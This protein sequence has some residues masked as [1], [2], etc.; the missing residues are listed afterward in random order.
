MYSISALGDM[1]ADEKRMD[2]YAATLQRAVTAD[3]AV[4]DIG[5]GTGIFALL[6]CQFG[7]RHVYAV[8]PD[9]AI[10]VARRIAHDNGYADQIT[11]IQDFSTRIS[12]PEP[13][14]VIISD[15]HGVLPYYEAHIPSI[16]D[17]RQRHLAA[18]GCLIPQRDTLW[19]TVVSA[20][21]V[22]SDMIKP[23]IGN[24]YNLP[25][26][27]ARQIVTNHWGREQLRPEQFLV[28]PQSWGTL[29]YAMITSPD[30]CATLV[31]TVEQGAT[32]HG[33]AVWF[34]TKLTEGI[35]LSNAPGMTELIYGHAFF[36]WTDPITLAAGDEITVTLQA[37]LIGDDYVWRWSTRVVSHHGRGQ[38]KANF[39]QSTLQGSLL[40][41]TQLAKRAA[42]HVAVLNEDGAIDR[43][44]LHAMDGRRP[45]GEIA[46][47]L[48]QEF[49]GHFSTW[50]DALGRVGKLSQR[51]SR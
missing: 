44:I 37:T 17:A 36:P 28:L 16:I 48:L 8:E 46:A 3:A 14:D 11:F 6:A 49:P 4:L 29:D 9:D 45:L 27:A 20:P 15:L 21:E 7:A 23:W 25:M 38:I 10:H 12:L 39:T 30:I 40:S 32:A 13:V 31:W 2:A 1:I 18:G 51:Y 26:Q 22:Y 43:F 42:H 35:C 5:T 41:P 33:L 47:A 24:K 19:A 34:D 50:H